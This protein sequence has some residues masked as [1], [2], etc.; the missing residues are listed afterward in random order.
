MA[1]SDHSC[2]TC[3]INSPPGAKSLL[4]A[5]SAA[6]DCI[7]NGKMFGLIADDVVYLKVDDS[8]RKLF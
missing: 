5:C 6:P 1:V 7:D 3:W 8:N 2:G 4:A